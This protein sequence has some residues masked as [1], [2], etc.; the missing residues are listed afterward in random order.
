MT[1]ALEIPDAQLEQ[2]RAV[3]APLGLSVEDLAR[4]IIQSQLAQSA[5]D[6]EEAAT[7]VLDKNHELYRRLG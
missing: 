4:A 5:E 1:L 7:R 3:A 2:L 6:F